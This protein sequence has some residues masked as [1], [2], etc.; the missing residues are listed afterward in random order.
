MGRFPGCLASCQPCH[1]SFGS[2]NVEYASE[3]VGEHAQTKLGS[4]FRQRSQQKI[5]VVPAALEGAE[6]MFDQRFALFEL[7]RLGGDPCGHPLQRFL[8]NQA[9]DAPRTMRLRTAL[10]QFA[11]SARL[12][13][14]VFQLAPVVGLCTAVIQ[15]L[16]TRAAIAITLRVV[17]K[18]LLCEQPPLEVF[19]GLR[20]SYVGLEP[21]LLTRCDFIAVVIPW[22]ATTARCSTLSACLA[23]TA[24]RASCC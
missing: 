13:R 7:I 5:T 19:G 2:Q 10:P 23:C 21:G 1:H 4:H 6:G 3:I 16:G 22:S 18:I 14:V 20:F 11:G 9:F 15:P 8:V 17:D 12:G 24:M